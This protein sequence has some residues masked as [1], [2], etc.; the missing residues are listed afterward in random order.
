MR[1]LSFHQ[2]SF[3]EYLEWN[4]IDKSKFKKINTLIKDIIRDPF[5]G[6]GKPELLK[7]QNEKYWSRR[8]SDEYRII[9]QVLPD[10]VIIISCKG[11]YQ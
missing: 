9:Y 3:Y 11:H 2:S 10:M 4:E 7:Y 8:I 6:I 5:T 1:L